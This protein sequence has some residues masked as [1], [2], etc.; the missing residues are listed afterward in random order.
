MAEI[1]I[2]KDRAII[3]AHYC[4]MWDHYC[5]G[6]TENG[7]RGVDEVFDTTLYIGKCWIGFTLW[8]IGGWERLLR[9]MPLRK[10]TRGWRLWILKP[11]NE[12]R[13]D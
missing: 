3:N 1:W 6:V 4:P 8:H 2:G 13:R 9:W 10:G 7:G 5:F 11:W 12:K